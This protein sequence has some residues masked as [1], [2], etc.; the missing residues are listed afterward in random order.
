MTEQDKLK[1]IKDILLKD[2]IELTQNYIEKVTALDEQLNNQ[3]QLSQKVTPIINKELNEFVAK[4]PETLGPTIT[5]T[6]Q[7]EIANS[8]DQVVEALYPIMGKMIKKYV[9]Q[10]I[11]LLGERIN[12]QL[13]NSFSA[14]SWKRRFK[15]WFG[16]VKQEHILIAEAQKPN[17]ES[18]G[19]Y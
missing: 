16:G 6:L 14:K 3:S 2:N 13:E 4:M 5:K 9:Q 10:E 19:Y 18:P 1:I 11:K 7:Q 12:K 8:K 17:I 15:S